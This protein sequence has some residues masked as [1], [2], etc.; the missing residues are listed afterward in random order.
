MLPC[1]ASP[2]L[3]SYIPVFLLAYFMAAAAFISLSLPLSSLYS[4]TN[5]S[6][7][8]CFG[9]SFHRSSVSLFCDHPACGSYDV[10]ALLPVGWSSLAFQCRFLPFFCLTSNVSCTFA[11]RL[12]VFRIPSPARRRR[13]GCAMFCFV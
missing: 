10:R 6:S 5:S 9:S 1:R 12:F 4:S 2:R 7:S 8:A 13:F 11:D 3:A